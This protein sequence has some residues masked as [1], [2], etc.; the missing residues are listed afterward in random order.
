MNGPEVVQ[1]ARRDMGISA[2]AHVAQ[3]RAGTELE[4][5]ACPRFKTT[6]QAIGPFH[7][8]G[9]LLGQFAF[10]G[11]RVQH[12]RPINAAQQSYTTACFTFGRRFFQRSLK[13]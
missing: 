7:S 8:M 10:A 13:C 5:G 6:L 4:K 1:A 11:R 3:G 9:D 12:G 2:C